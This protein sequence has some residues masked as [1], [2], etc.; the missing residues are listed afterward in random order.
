MIKTESHFLLQCPKYKK[1][2]KIL[3]QNIRNNKS[4]H[5]KE[6]TAVGELSLVLEKLQMAEI[7]MKWIESNSQFGNKW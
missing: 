7:E 2:K 5:T 6:K 3:P 1:Q 4:S